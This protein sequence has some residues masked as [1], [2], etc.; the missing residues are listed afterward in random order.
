VDAVEMLRLV[1]MNG[2]KTMSVVEQHVAHWAA[3]WDT[4]QSDAARRHQ[5]ALLFEPLFSGIPG[6]RVTEQH[7]DGVVHNWDRQVAW[8]LRRA[9]LLALQRKLIPADLTDHIVAFWRAVAQEH[10]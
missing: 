7:I 1:A 5:A 6:A 8:H 4:N 2:E 3:V 9:A 10:K